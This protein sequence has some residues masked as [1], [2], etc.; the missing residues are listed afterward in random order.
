MSYTIL[1]VNEIQDT[2]QQP[3]LGVNTLL[4]G[5][6]ALQSSEYNNINQIKANLTT[7]FLTV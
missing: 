2:T 1:S 5:G 3:G 7:L 4:A 6:P